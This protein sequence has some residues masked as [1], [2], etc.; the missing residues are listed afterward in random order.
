[1]RFK[2]L[3]MAFL[4]VTA[5]GAFIASSAFA[6]NSFN[7]AKSA[8]YTGSSPGTKLTGGR[9][10]TAKADG[11]ALS[12]KTTWGGKTLTLDAKTVECIGCKIENSG[13]VA[14][15]KGKLK[16]GEVTLAEPEPTVCGAPSTIETKAL[17]A[18]L[19]MGGSGTAA[20]VKFE[21]EAG[22]ST[23][24]ATFEFTGASCSIAGTYKVTG[25]VVGEAQNATGV[26]AEEQ[27]ISF[28]Q[29]IQESGLEASSLK[30]GANNAFLTGTVSN[31]IGG[32]LWA[33]KES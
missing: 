26:F 28:S 21:P 10:L 15:A 1:M 25:A 9:T 3:G 6:A 23:A 32:T 27:T 13:A 30:F 11:V 4:V 33:G 2:K 24:F 12:L 19:G 5:L 8:W 18:T 16:F 31:S 17:K 20:T 14:I 22:T 7:G 29:A